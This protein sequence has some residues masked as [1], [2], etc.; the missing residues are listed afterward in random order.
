MI[1]TSLAGGLGNQLF[2]YSVGFNL[3]KK[4]KQRL[5]LDI[6][7]FQ[8]KHPEDNRQYEF[9]LDKIIFDR[10]LMVKGDIKNI[11]S[12]IDIIKTSQ[13]NAVLIKKNKPIKSI[14]DIDDG[15]YYVKIA[16]KMKKI[17]VK[18]LDLS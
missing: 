15:I 14:D 1:I 7:F 8:K 6:S 4:T 9:I 12:N 10:F 17:E 3:S 11:K 5:I 16:G 2:Q 13:Y 18:I